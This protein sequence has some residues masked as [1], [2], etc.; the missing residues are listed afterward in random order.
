VEEPKHVKAR[1]GSRR[2]EELAAALAELIAPE[3]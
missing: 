1:L 2:A 3:G